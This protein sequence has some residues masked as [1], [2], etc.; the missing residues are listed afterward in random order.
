M[1]DPWEVAN[2]ANQ[3]A[4]TAMGLYGTYGTLKQG[5]EALSE[6]SRQFDANM[7]W[8]K[9]QNAS[10]MEF[11][12]RQHSEQMDFASRQLNDNVSIAN[13]NLE[14]QQNAFDYQKQL[15]ST[16]MER[17]DSA[18]QRLV[19]DYKRAGF[20]PL[21]A[22]GSSGASSSPLSSGQAPQLDTTGINQASGQYAEFARQYSQLALAAKQDYMK[23]RSQLAE[24]HNSDI[25]AAKFTLRQMK[26][27]MLYKN[28]S[29]ANEMFNTQVNYRN[30]KMQNQY[31]E[32]QFKYLQDKHKWESNNGFRGQ[33]AGQVLVNAIT[34]YLDSKKKDEGATRLSTAYNV[35]KETAVKVGVTVKEN[36]DKLPEDIKEKIN[37]SGIEDYQ[38]VALTAYT[39]YLFHPIKSLKENCL[40]VWE[41]GKDLYQK[42]IKKGK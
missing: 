21:A 24:K 22:I 39:E 26:N 27:D 9:Q 32:E 20:S 35:S 30:A 5:E 13:K 4:Q 7:N 37:N 40:S 2:Q 10:A 3:V 38:K 19:E 18:M 36:L 25:T 29:F 33:T 6:S 12:N 15:N 41:A 28:M 11:A 16:Q 8:L 31:L 42:Y 17:E 23:N 1:A 14:M 34:E